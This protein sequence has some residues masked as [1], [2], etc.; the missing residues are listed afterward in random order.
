[1][2]AKL[3]LWCEECSAGRENSVK[4]EFTGGRTLLEHHTTSM[5]ANVNPWFNIFSNFLEKECSMKVD[6]CVFPAATDSRF[7]RALG[8]RAIGFSPMRS[9]PV[10][11]HEHDEYLNIDIYYEG[12]EVYIHLMMVL[13]SQGMFDGDI[14]YYGATATTKS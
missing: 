1:M 3:N 10:L 6:P 12:C 2:V 5:D 14:S 13:G 4:W 8:I 11:L 9:S 7:L